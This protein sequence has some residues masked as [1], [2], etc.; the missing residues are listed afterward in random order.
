M[1]SKTLAEEAA[2]KFAIVT[3]NPGLVI[4]HFSQPTLNISMEPVL[5]LVNG[6]QEQVSIKFHYSLI[7]YMILSSNHSYRRTYFEGQ[8]PS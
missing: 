4:N 5:K 1:I 3:I 7:Y 6:T 2:W 8:D